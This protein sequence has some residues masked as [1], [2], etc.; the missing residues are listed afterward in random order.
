MHYILGKGKKDNQQHERE[1]IPYWWDALKRIRNMLGRDIC[2]TSTFHSAFC[3]MKMREIGRSERPGMLEIQVVILAVPLPNK[4]N[5]ISVLQVHKLLVRCVLQAP[6]R[7]KGFSPGAA[8]TCQRRY[9]FAKVG[10]SKWCTVSQFQISVQRARSFG[11]WCRMCAVLADAC[12]SCFVP[13]THA[14]ASIL[15]I[16]KLNS[17]WD[18]LNVRDRTSI[19]YIR[20]RLKRFLNSLRNVTDVLA[21]AQLEFRDYLSSMVRDPFST[22]RLLNSSQ[23]LAALATESQQEIDFQ[24]LCHEVHSSISMFDAE[25][26]N[27][28]NDIVRATL[29]VANSSDALGIIASAAA[30]PNQ[31]QF[32]IHRISTSLVP[33]KPTRTPSP[34]PLHFHFSYTSLLLLLDAWMEQARL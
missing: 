19:T 32:S 28:S 16:C 23:H 8:A 31:S 29:P 26:R 14:F 3:G 1:Q 4:R 34:F 5:I 18:L 11:K 13:L 27:A 15:A 25:Q 12:R 24:N 9:N 2:D 10:E 20:K 33:F 21:Y 17:L 30:N 22:V 7:K 6:R